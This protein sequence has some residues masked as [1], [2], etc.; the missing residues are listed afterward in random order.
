MC[1]TDGGKGVGCSGGEG[2]GF[3]VALHGIQCDRSDSTY[4]HLFPENRSYHAVVT[5]F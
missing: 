2:S 1:Q 3:D 5:W 4:E